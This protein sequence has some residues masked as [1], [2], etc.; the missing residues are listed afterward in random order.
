[1]FIGGGVLGF[2]AGTTNWVAIVAACMMAAGQGM[3]FL[4][5]IELAPKK[6]WPFGVGV[7]FGLF[8]L[9]GLLSLSQLKK[10]P[11]LHKY[12]DD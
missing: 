8:G 3:F 1:M 12:E 11:V 9:I 6:G 7:F 4:V 2:Y 10:R 5:C